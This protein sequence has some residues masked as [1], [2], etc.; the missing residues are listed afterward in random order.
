MPWDEAVLDVVG[1]Q[2]SA[3]RVRRLLRGA[4]FG[5]VG[6]NPAGF[7]TC[8]VDHAALREKLGVE[9]LQLDL[10]ED[11]FAGMRAVPHEATDTV[12][13]RLET[14]VAGLETMDADATRGT[15]SAYVALKTLASE[16][17]LHGFAVRCWPEFFTEMGCAACGA[18]SLLSDDMLHR[19]PASCEADVNGTITQ[20]ILQHL[21][22]LPAVGMD[23]VSVDDAADAL[24]LWH[25][26]LA[27]L[28]MAEPGT[29]PGVTLHS[30][31]RLPLLMDFML[32]PGLV[33]VARLSAATGELRLVIG[34]ARM[35][36]GQ[37]PFSGTCGLLCFDRPARSVLDTILSEGLEHHL[38]LSYGDQRPALR[39]LARLLRL[40]ILEL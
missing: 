4:R 37:K 40:P 24:V 8:L 6:E 18:I 31:R 33:T 34:S 20:F 27:P 7:E 32:K 12:A 28:W 22:G 35:V 15:L 10:R 1:E 17:N 23:I 30:N 13:A 16:Q 26:G 21:T 39:A 29:T 25:C 9:V 19:L 5:R 3:G 36:G 38:S 14:Q 2:F 11:V